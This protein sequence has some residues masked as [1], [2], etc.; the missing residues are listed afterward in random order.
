M[1][2]SL[3]RR[4]RRLA[5]STISRVEQYLQASK[6]P[7]KHAKID[8]EEQTLDQDCL[9]LSDQPSPIARMAKLLFLTLLTLLILVLILAYTIYK[10]PPLLI[11]YLQ[12]KYRP[13]IFHL[14]LPPSHRTIA[15]TIDDAPSDHTPAILDLLAK[16]HAAATF[17]II[18]SQAQ[19]NPSVIRSIHEAGHELGNHAWNDEPSISLPLSELERQVKEVEAL[20]PP[21]ASGLKFFRPGS[22]FFNGKMVGLLAGLGYRVA[23]GSVYPHDA[24]ITNPRWNAA[25]VLSM[26]RPGGVIIMHDRRGY[27][28]EEIRLVLEGLERGGWK[29][30]SLGELVRVSEEVEGK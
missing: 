5:T 8:D 12:Q 30:V 19:E 22:G 1:R 14:P 17:F 21:N 29:V 23:L 6:P 7:R 25:H 9:L 13:V 28:V 3:I 10:P 2:I 26:V 18:G 27:S 24:Q 16:H 20:L 4:I 15:L 11:N